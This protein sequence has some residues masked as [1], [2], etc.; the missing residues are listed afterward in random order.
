VTTAN[1][2]SPCRKI[3]AIDKPSGL[4]AGC[5]RTLQEIAAWSASND[6]QKR[7]I[8]AQLP[9]RMALLLKDRRAAG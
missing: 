1:I 4:C 8:L 3:C 7:A 5:G 9:A 6:G 2:G